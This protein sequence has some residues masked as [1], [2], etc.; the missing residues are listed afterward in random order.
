KGIGYGVLRYGAAANELAVLAQP[1][2]TFN[3]LG[4]FDQQFGEDALFVPAS[5]GGGQAQSLGAP[6]ANWLS[7]EGRVYAGELE[8]DWSFSGEVFRRDTI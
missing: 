5:E 3:Y 1:R 7:V 2:I 6:L 8:L 4:Q